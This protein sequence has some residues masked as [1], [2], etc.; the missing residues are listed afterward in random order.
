MNRNC[1]ASCRTI[2]VAFSLVLEKMMASSNYRVMEFTDDNG[3]HYYQI[4]EVYY[5]NEGHPSSYTENPAVVF[6]IDGVDGLVGVLDKM[7][8]ALKKPILDK[9]DFEKTSVIT[10]V[11]GNVFLDLGFSPDEAKAL[12]DES[13]KKMQKRK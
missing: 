1:A 2:S 9:I 7:K 12:Q 8:E 4:H 13:N 11:G 10:P 3:E 6:S 5:D